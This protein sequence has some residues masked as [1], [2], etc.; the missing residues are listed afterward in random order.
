[1]SEISNKVNRHKQVLNKSEPI[2]ETGNHFMIPYM[3][4]FRGYCSK[5]N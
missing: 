5:I 4:D 1:L 2:I 3:C